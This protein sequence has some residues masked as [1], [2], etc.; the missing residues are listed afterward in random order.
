MRSYECTNPHMDGWLVIVIV[1]VVA[2]NPVVYH[3]V[4]YQNGNGLGLSHL[5]THIQYIT[6]LCF[7][8]CHELSWYVHVFSFNPIIESGSANPSNPLENHDNYTVYIYSYTITPYKIIIYPLFQP[9]ATPSTYHG[10]PAFFVSTGRRPSSSTPT[11]LGR[12]PGDWWY[13]W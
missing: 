13:V 9:G 7:Y 2:K 10:D 4:P 3:H 8:I 12:R 6:I 5:H 1:H 11:L